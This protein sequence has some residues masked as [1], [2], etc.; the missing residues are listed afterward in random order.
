[1]SNDMVS[2]ING[3]GIQWRPSVLSRQAVTSNSTRWYG[4]PCMRWYSFWSRN[5]MNCK[6]LLE[7]RWVELDLL[8]GLAYYGQFHSIEDQ[9]HESSRQ[10]HH[11]LL[12][13]G[14]DIRHR[15]TI[16]QRSQLS[17][18]WWPTPS[19]VVLSPFVCLTKDFERETSS[20]KE[21]RRSLSSSLRC[22]WHSN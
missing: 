9:C 19:C 6:C 21:K 1:M 18:S 11:C 22:R 10:Y 4:M 7:E 8:K 12:L 2:F 13:S 5:G 20:P 17:S 15:P 14:G 16:R 3:S